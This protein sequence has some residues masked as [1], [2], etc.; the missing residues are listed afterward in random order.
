MK[1]LLVLGL[2]CLLA[3]WQCNT[4]RV[5]DIYTENYIYIN[6]TSWTLNIKSYYPL[7]TDKDPNFDTYSEF[8]IDRGGSHKISCVFS[9]AGGWSEPLYWHPDQFYFK[10]DS[11]VVSN[12]IVQVVYRYSDGGKLY[13]P[14]NY[15]LIEEGKRTCTY[16]Y[17]FT[18][19]DFADAEPITPR[20]RRG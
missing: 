4:K 6:E 13:F 18:D 17:T 12:G 9:G 16:Q 2:P 5:E 14:E 8:N 1:K 10:Y 11:T 7:P 15:V 20:S 3:L 19:D